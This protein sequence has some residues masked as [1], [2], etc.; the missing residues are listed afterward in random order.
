MRRIVPGVVLVTAGVA[1][2]ARARP[3]LRQRPPRWLRSHQGGV[4]VCHQML[5]GATAAPDE[6]LSAHWR[7]W[8][9]RQGITFREGDPAAN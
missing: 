9:E 3:H 8:A 4:C 5:S 2:T 1:Q 6:L 7:K